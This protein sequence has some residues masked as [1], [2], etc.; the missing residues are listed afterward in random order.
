MIYE[1]FSIAAR[2]LSALAFLNPTENPEI[3][4]E[5]K[6]VLNQYS[7]DLVD[8]FDEY[9]INGRFVGFDRQ[10]NEIR[11][12][13]LFPPEHWPVEDNLNLG[14]LRTQNNVEAWHRRW[15]ALIGRPHIAL[16]KIIRE[17]KKN[18]MRPR[19]KLRD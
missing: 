19:Y 11:N 2:Q 8:W 16:L 5:L 18:R 4:N 3:F 7:S 17:I 13:P 6:I 12:P 14:L 9:Y 10:K 1:N 15:S